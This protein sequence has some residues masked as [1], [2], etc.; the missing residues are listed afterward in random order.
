MNCFELASVLTEGT[1]V[2]LMGTRARGKL[3][4]R[5]VITRTSNLSLLRVAYGQLKVLNIE[6]D[7]TQLIVDV[8]VDL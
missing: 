5:S 6:V 7:S 1:V 2:T 4:K 8:L 3:D